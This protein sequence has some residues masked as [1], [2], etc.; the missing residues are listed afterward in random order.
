MHETVDIERYLSKRDPDLGRAIEIVSAAK[1]APLRPPPSKD[2]VF[3][4]LVRAV[5]YQRTSEASGSTVYSQP[6][7]D[8][9]RQARSRQ[10]ILSL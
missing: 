7:K 6:R 8:R 2:N 3:Q 5:I 4:S 10:T 9:R 1:G